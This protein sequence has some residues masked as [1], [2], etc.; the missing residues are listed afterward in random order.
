[1]GSAGSIPAGT[2]F[3]ELKFTFTGIRDQPPFG[4]WSGFIQLSAIKLYTLDGEEFNEIDS[5]TNPNGNRGN[6]SEG[7]SRLLETGMFDVLLE[8]TKFLL[9]IL[10]HL[11]EVLI[12]I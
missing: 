1:M 3:D 7:P 4:R 11:L 8:N 2:P 5:C 6:S 9:Y 12:F 10:I